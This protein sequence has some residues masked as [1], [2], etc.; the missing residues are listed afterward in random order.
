MKWGD[1]SDNAKSVLEWVTHVWT[2]K[3]QLLM[4]VKDK[5]FVQY[6]TNI[7][8][9]KELFAEI[10]NYLLNKEHQDLYYTIGDELITIALKTKYAVDLKSQDI[11]TIMLLYYYQDSFL[12]PTELA[13]MG[14]LHKGNEWILKS[15]SSYLSQSCSRLNQKGLVSRNEKGHYQISNN[16]K[17]LIK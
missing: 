9:S 4:I 8:I 3:D 10:S 2:N 15:G 17:T 13:R 7:F 6:D 12:G 5:P 14:W 11:Q 1:L 16:G